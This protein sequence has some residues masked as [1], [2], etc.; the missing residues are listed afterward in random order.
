[1]PGLCFSRNFIEAKFKSVILVIK[2]IN[3]R[4]REARAVAE[5]SQARFIEDEERVYCSKDI[6]F[7]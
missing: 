3:N 6:I 1:M 2:E 4:E 7:L 5:L